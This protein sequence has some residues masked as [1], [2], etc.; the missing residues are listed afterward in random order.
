MLVFVERKAMGRLGN[1]PAAPLVISH[2]YSQEK[3]PWKSLSSIENC[4]ESEFLRPVLLG[5]SILPYRVFQPF[6]CVI[7]VTRKGEILDSTA[8]G[9]RGIGG[10]FGWLRKAE[11][12]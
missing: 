1:D 2:K 6:E 9:N 12:V 8:A 11:A 7:P 5:E 4:I 10:L 3:Q